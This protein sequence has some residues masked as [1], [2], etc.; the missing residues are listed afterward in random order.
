MTQIEKAEAMK[1]AGNKCQVCG[2]KKG[3]YVFRGKHK[4]ES[5]YQTSDAKTY[6]AITGTLI[7]ISPFF[8]ITGQT[9]LSTSKLTKL[10]VALEND[11]VLVLCQSCALRR[12]H[13]AKAKTK[14]MTTANKLF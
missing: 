2:V 13:K 11:K 9:L 8:E 14:S 1:S 5:V 12:R 4:G 10:Q 7:S 3:T 6:C